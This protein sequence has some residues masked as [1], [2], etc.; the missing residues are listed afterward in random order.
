MDGPGKAAVT[1]TEGAKVDLKAAEADSAEGW[2]SCLKRIRGSIPQKY[3]HE[4]VQ[5]FK[6]A[7]PVVRLRLLCGIYSLITYYDIYFISYLPNAR[8]HNLLY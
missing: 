7:G 3:R 1:H 6:L 2:G 5:L 4:L 8:N